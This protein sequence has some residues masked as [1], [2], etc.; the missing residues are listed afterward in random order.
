M[1][2]GAIEG[3]RQHSKIRFFITMLTL[4]S[5]SK[6]FGNA[7]YGATILQFAVDGNRRRV[8]PR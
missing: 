7:A 4:T 1:L 8:R 3:S 6:S 2:P 5:V